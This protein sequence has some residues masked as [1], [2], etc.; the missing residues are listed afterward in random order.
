M[1]KDRF[2]NINTA[3][4]QI[5]RQRDFDAAKERLQKEFDT[6]D[7]NGD[8]LVTLDE[9]QEFLNKKVITTHII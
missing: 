5:E 8:G 3:K 1:F 7:F 9:L 4:A 6:I 2:S